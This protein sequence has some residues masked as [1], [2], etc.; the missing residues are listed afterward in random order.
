MLRSK[1]SFPVITTACCLLVAGLFFFGVNCGEADTMN[2][3]SPQNSRLTESSQT[4]AWNIF[5]EIAS[6]TDTDSNICISPLSIAYVL[7]LSYNAATG[8]VQKEIGQALQVQDIDIKEINAAY[9]D[10]MASLT[11]SDPDVTLDIANSFWYR[12][13]MPVVSTYVET[14]RT[15]YDAEVRPL[16]FSKPEAADKINGWVSDNTKEKIT[17]IVSGPL[18]SDLVAI[19][20]N[21]VY[22]KAAWE[23]PFDPRM[24]KP[25]QFTRSDGSQVER[26]FMKNRYDFASYQNDKFMAVDFPYGDGAMSMAVLLPSKTSSADDVIAYLNKETW[27]AT[28]D[29]FEEG[30]DIA[31][32]LPK[33]RFTAEYGL[34]DDLQSL[35]MEKAFVPAD[36]ANMIEGGGIWIDSVIHK[37]FIQT[38]EEGSEA[39]AATAAMFKKSLALDFSVNRPFVFVIYD[40]DSSTILFAGRIADPVWE[41]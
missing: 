19:L 34:K 16:D 40:K 15:F 12:A 14:A 7:A 35:G 29:G 32:N 27:Q 5:H 2:H 37:T 26:M 18:D 33:F 22:F 38:D 4:F 21:A 9:R 8:E 1:T 30:T 39:A 24:S 28:V 41:E 25:A 10:L 23:L 31:V 6:R 3:P 13:D 20:I 11:Q 17:D 36:F